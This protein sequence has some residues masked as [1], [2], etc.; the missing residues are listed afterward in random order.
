MSTIDQVEDAW[1]AGSTDFDEFIAK[2]EVDFM[3]PVELRFQK[4]MWATLT[5]VDKKL[6]QAMAPEAFEEVRKVM[7]R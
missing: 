3:K 1:L 4:M 7:E 2:F 5:D 6:L